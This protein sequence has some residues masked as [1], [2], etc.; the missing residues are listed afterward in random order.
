M[1]KQADPLCRINLHYNTIDF[2]SSALKEKRNVFTY[3]ASL[4]PAS[5]TVLLGVE[6][7]ESKGAFKP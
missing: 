3:V 6:E 7:G 2:L 4:I 5:L 1:A